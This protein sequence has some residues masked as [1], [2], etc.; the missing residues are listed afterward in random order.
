[1]SLRGCCGWYC[2]PV[3]TL[4]IAARWSSVFAAAMLAAATGCPGS[5]SFACQD[6][7]SCHT[8]GAIGSCEDNGY[9]S[10]PDAECPSGRRF[11]DLA[12]GGFAGLCVELGN[13]STGGGGPI[14]D[15]GTGPP[16]T[17]DEAAETLAG[18]GDDTAGAGLTSG[19]DSSG[20]D[21]G[22]SNPQTSGTAGSDT[23]ESMGDSG[24]ATTDN[25]A[26]DGPDPSCNLDVDDFEDGVI[27]GQWMVILGQHLTETNGALVLTITG[28]SGDGYP[29]VRRMPSP[30]DFS[31]GHLRMQVGQPALELSSQM[32]I[33]V[34]DDQGSA[35][36]FMI[37]GGQLE[38]LYSIDFKS[39]NQ[40]AFTPYD[41]VAHR[42]LQ[43]RFVGDSV[44]YETSHDGIEYESFAQQ[45]LPFSVGAMTPVLV[46]GN[47][48]ELD[49]P[50]QVSVEHF[51]VCTLSD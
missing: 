44:V 37:N 45:V 20:E 49:D 12:G 13:G 30:T 14:A 19:V 6:D 31:G 23:S 11:G 42:W 1:M 41:A 27:D 25:G 46:G 33:G 50:V 9:C 10:F 36:S 35:V 2:C 24:D 18:D 21:G 8:D 5:G 32:W 22:T 29:Q 17:G 15:E 34:F 39:A 26:T 7:V 4:G 3:G 28:D 43:L 38:A 40:V 48:A 51:E 47:W 16:P